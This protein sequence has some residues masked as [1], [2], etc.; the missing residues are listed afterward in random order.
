MRILASAPTAALP[1]K[2][3]PQ[4][5]TLTG[6]A[7]TAGSWIYEIKF[8]GYR[9]L[10]RL[11]DGTARLFT[12]NGHDWTSKMQSLAREVERS[13]IKNGWLDCE[14]VVMGPDG[15][16]SFN[17]LQNAFDRIAT[18]DIV[19]YVFDVPFLDSKNLCGLPLESRRAILRE[20]LVDHPSDRIRFSESFRADGPSVLQSACKMGLEGV[21]AK[22]VDARY[23]MRRTQTWLKLKCQQRQEFVVG[24]FTERAGAHQDVGSL[25]LGVYDDE[26]QLH[27]VGNVGT[28]WSGTEGTAMRKRLNK[29]ET[30]TSPFDSRYAPRVGRWSKRQSGSER[31]VKPTLVVEVIFTEWTADGNIRHP[32]FVALRDDKAAADIRREKPQ[33]QVARPTAA[34]AP[35]RS[36]F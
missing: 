4:L 35:K 24:G 5:A 1:A 15:L 14:A 30:P 36:S 16:P 29:I 22:R 21:I 34:A 9:I 25:L 27:S 11:E 26:G 31:W 19:L 8:D 20:R 7:P 6:A 18:E 23:E 32:S 13:G 10:A 12:R 2:L 28:G 33:S 17:A 3:S